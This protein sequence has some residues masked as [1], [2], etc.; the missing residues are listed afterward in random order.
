MEVV[1][2]AG[3]IGHAKLQSNRY[4][5]QTN[6]KSFLQTG[7]PSCHPTNSVKQINIFCC[8]IVLATVFNKSIILITD[9]HLPKNSSTW[10]TAEWLKQ[11]FFRQIICG[12]HKLA[13]SNFIQYTSHVQPRSHRPTYSL[14]GLRMIKK[15]NFSP[16]WYA[17]LRTGT[18][19]LWCEHIQPCV[20]SQNSPAHSHMNSQ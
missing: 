7:C 16:E 19:K 2:T 13:I 12:G 5:Q 9:S 17:T 10:W 4:H 1:V 15:W 14:S 3:T 8:L 20:V 11:H 6:T 18:A